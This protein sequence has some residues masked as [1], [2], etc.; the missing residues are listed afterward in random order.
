[1]Q[2]ATSIHAAFLCGLSIQ[3]ASPNAGILDEV[4]PATPREYHYHGNFTPHD[5]MVILRQYVNAQTIRRLEHVP[6]TP[7]EFRVW[8]SAC[9]NSYFER[10]HLYWPVLH[11]HSFDEQ[12]D[13]LIVSATVVL[14]GAWLQG[15]EATKPL[16]LETHK[17]LVDHLL[18][19]MVSFKVLD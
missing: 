15:P 6:N 19:Q 9:C 2:N 16:I 4:G 11:R 3:P 10:F 17:I 13:P 7:I 18:E 1:M 5:G 14:I 8:V 12:G